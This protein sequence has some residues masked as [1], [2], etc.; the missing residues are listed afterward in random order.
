MRDIIY[1]FMFVRVEDSFTCAHFIPVKEGEN[2]RDLDKF[3]MTP[4]FL[5]WWQSQA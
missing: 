4:G 3:E 1:C 5:V 2:T